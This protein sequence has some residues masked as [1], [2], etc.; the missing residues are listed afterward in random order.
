MPIAVFAIILR[1]KRRKLFVGSYPEKGK[2]SRII[3]SIIKWMNCEIHEGRIGGE[4]ENKFWR[5][6]RGVLILHSKRHCNSGV[7]VKARSEGRQVYAS[8]FSAAVSMAE[9]DRGVTI[10]GGT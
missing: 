10:A 8:P 4:I 2:L 6:A 7:L 1:F 3:K 9:Y 5:G